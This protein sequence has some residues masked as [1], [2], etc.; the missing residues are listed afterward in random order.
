[1]AA[2][3]LRLEPRAEGGDETVWA[4]WVMKLVTLTELSVRFQFHLCNR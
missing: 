3:A 1:M 2:D 4:G